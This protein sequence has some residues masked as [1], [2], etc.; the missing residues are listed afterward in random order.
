[1]ISNKIYKDISRLQTDHKNL[2]RPFIFNRKDY[3]EQLI[4]T[5]NYMKDEIERTFNARVE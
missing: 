1:M 3:K 4:I 2:N 5:I